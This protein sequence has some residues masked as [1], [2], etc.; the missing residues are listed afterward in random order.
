MAR[1]RS[2]LAKRRAELTRSLP[3]L[4]EKRVGTYRRNS[5]ALA[6]DRAGG[7][8]ERSEEM[9][10]LGEAE[11]AADAAVRDV[12]REL[13]DVDAEIRLMPRRSLG[14]GARRAVRRARQPVSVLP[15]TRRAVDS[16]EHP[17][18]FMVA[19]DRPRAVSVAAKTLEAPAMRLLG[20][21]VAPPD[22]HKRT[23]RRYC[24]G[25]ARETEQIAGAADGRG[26]IPA[27]RW[28]ITEPAIGTTICLDCGQRR[29]PSSRPNPPAWSSWPRSRIATRSVA[30]AA[31]ATHTTEDW[32]SES[33]AEDEGMP[34]KREPRA[35]SA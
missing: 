30:L 29:A 15:L 3:G 26:S 20:R 5:D 10:R 13:R 4:S 24:S 1:E 16:F 2:E 31:Y 12:Q 8:R 22:R 25:C 6:L 32:L 9:V 14:A 35:A 21:R 7:K 17:G 19:L 23:R 28:P 27:I 33:A 34:P 11:V 18:L